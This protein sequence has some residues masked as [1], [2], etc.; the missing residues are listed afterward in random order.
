[1]IWVIAGTVDGR[2]LAVQIQQ[3][4]QEAVLVSVVS[5]YGAQLAAHEGI[6]VHQGRLDKEAM[7]ALIR[8]KQVSLL[9]DA[10]HP[11]CGGGDRYRSRSGR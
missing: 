5:Q 10:S 9:V 1:M 6:E 8:D 2:T 7:E 11:L 4:T 3:H